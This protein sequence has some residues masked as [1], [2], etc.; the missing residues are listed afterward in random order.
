MQSLTNHNEH[1]ICFGKPLQEKTKLEGEV[2]ML[3]FVENGNDASTN[4]KA[5]FMDLH[6]TYGPCA[7]TKHK[8][9]LLFSL[10]LSTLIYSSLL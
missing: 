4:E 2:I 6:E 5:L 7:A 8:H 10:S 1:H 9:P 3:S